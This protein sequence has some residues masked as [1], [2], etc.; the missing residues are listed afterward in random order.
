MVMHKLGAQFSSSKLQKGQPLSRF[1]HM[2]LDTA[3]YGCC[4][5]HTSY[6]R[7]V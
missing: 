7:C 4:S 1:H 2:Q 6:R 5:N 3:I